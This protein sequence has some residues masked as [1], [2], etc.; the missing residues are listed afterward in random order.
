MIAAIV[1]AYCVVIFLAGAVVG[2]LAGVHLGDELH[3]LDVGDDQ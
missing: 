1:V 3:R 2:M